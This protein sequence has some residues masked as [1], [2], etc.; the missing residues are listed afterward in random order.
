MKPVA[1]SLIKGV[2]DVLWN[3]DAE[4]VQIKKRSMAGLIKAAKFIR[5]ETDTVTPMI[6]VDTGNLRA[7]W[8]TSPYYTANYSPIVILGF[9]A[10]YAWYVHE[11]VGANF[12]QPKKGAKGGN[13]R[14]AKFL[15][16]ALNR[17]HDNILE[18]IR[19]AARVK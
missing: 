10:L 4:V 3:L 7:S 15:E 16:A 5:R 9:S 2:D 18:I 1:G 14:G 11:M 13:Q 17:N 8:F 19:E 12:N 6:P